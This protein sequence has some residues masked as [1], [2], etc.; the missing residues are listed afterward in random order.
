MSD[1]KESNYRMSKSLYDDDNNKRDWDDS[2]CIDFLFFVK[3][4][5]SLL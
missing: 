2:F 5:S 1:V 3:Y 4:Y